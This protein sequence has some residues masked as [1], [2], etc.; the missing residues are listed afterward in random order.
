[1]KLEIGMFVRV[2][3]Y[4]IPGKIVEFW[5]GNPIVEFV[6]MID[7]DSVIVPVQRYT[8]EPLERK[9]LKCTV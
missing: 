8:G 7:K 3:D 2:K 5:E 6:Q 9:E 4:S 1:M